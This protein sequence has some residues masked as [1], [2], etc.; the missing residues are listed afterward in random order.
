V[1]VYEYRCVECDDTFEQRRPMAAA[2][3]G[4]TCPDGHTEVRRLLSVFAT[5]GRA[6][7]GAGSSEMAMG[8]P[9]GA[10]CACHPG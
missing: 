3:D 2:D 8:A 7:A 5:A 1:P 10:H 6:T 9:C 4:V